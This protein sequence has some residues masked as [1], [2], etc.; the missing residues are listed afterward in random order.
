VKYSQKTCPVQCINVDYSQKT[1]P[2]QCI[3]V[4]YSQKTCPV[5]CTNVKYSQNRS[6]YCTVYKCEV[7]SE[8]KLVLYSV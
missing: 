1:C 2:V 5:Q 6:L 8:Q 3:N 7:Q 4:D